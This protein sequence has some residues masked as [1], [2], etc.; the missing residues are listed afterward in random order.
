MSVGASGE[1]FIFDHETGIIYHLNR[2][3][4]L[5]FQSIQNE[6]RCSMD[7]LTEE[8]ASSYLLPVDQISQEIEE[9]LDQLCHEGLAAWINN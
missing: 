7:G 4:T 3:G 1:S 5:V 9:F 6:G 2:L 8:I